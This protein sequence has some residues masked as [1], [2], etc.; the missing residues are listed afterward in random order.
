MFQQRSLMATALLLV[1]W[2]SWRGEAN[3]RSYFLVKEPVAETVFTSEFLR[4]ARIRPGNTTRDEMGT[5]NRK[6]NLFTEGWIYLPGLLSYS[7]ELEPEWE[8]ESNQVQTGEKR[9]L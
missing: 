8:S 2:L 9:A 5:F 1:V 6:L 4:D 3:G 7:I